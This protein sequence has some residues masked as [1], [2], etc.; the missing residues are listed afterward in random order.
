MKSIIINPIDVHLFSS[1]SAMSSNAKVAI[2][3]PT[4]ENTIR[5][6]NKR[7]VSFFVADLSSNPCS[8]SLEDGSGGVSDSVGGVSDSVGGVSDCVGGVSDSV[9]GE[10]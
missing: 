6:Q 1:T 7:S 5:I 4:T 8:A 9:G 10:S 2:I 3:P